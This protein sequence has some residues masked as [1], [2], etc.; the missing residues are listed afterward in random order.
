MRVCMTHIWMH[1]YL[2]SSPAPL[3][4]PF[5]LPHSISLPSSLRSSFLYTLSHSSPP[6][7]PF[8]PF[9]FSSSP[10][11]LSS[12]LPPSLYFL[13]PL[14]T[15]SSLSSLLPPSLHSFLPL[16]LPSLLSSI[17]PTF[18]S[19]LPPLST[20]P[21]VKVYIL[22]KGKKHDKWKST[23]KR[24]TLLPIF[25]EP[26]QFDISNLNVL[27][28]SLEFVVM[29]YDRFS[30]DDLVGQVLV[31]P[32]AKDEMGQTHWEELISNPNQPISRWHAIY[33]ASED[34]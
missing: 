2:H 20:D 18:P 14:F 28:L 22:H 27:D 31:G 17:T 12:L 1:I 23:I 10:F 8:L 19:S 29:D 13:L 21:Y 3:P 26:F 7:P 16:S 9:P 24:N 34:S 30:K 33:P 11:S 32:N 4:P 6:S 5:H 15:P 25:N